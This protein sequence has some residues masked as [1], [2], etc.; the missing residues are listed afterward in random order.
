[1]DEQLLKELDETEEVKL[2]GRS[3]VMR[4]ALQEYLLR[5][6]RR[7]IVEEYRRAYTKEEGLGKEF[8]GWEE[9]GA[10]PPD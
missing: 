4:R 6:R 8:E 3:A 2:D 9:Q 7:S 10:W 5:R 1:M